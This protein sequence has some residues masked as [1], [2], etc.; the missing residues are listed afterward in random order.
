MSIDEIL[1]IRQFSTIELKKENEKILIHGK[2][3]DTDKTCP[4]CNTLGIK[5]HQYHRKE[6]RTVPFNGK[7]TYLVFIHTAYKC[8]TCGKRYLERTDFFEKRRIYTIAYE[9]YIC[10]QAKKQDITRVS[11]LE[12]LN[13][14]TVND[15][16]LKGREK[17]GTAIKK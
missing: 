6:L 12:G 2:L 5:P 3:Q 17:K 7:P 10:E 9:K 15:I 4:I 16:F 13:W 14:H 8:P 1:E 11:E